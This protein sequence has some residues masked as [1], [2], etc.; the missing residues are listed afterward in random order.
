MR[1]SIRK[2]VVMEIFCK[3]YIEIKDIKHDQKKNVAKLPASFEE[4]VNTMAILNRLEKYCVVKE[5]QADVPAYVVISQAPSVNSFT[6]NIGVFLS[7]FAIFRVGQSAYNVE[8]K[9]YQ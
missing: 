4:T 2:K 7:D 9:F 1:N 5:V 8:I 6:Q 3:T